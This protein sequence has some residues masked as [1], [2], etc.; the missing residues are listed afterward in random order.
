MKEVLMF[1]ISNLWKFI[2]MGTSGGILALFSFLLA[3]GVILRER[4]CF[5]GISKKLNR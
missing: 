2:S 1:V 3:R 4:N 5:L